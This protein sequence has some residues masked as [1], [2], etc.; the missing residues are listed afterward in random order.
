MGLGGAW[1]VGNQKNLTLTFYF[2]FF[3]FIADWDVTSQPQSD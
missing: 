3:Y 1:H 2:I